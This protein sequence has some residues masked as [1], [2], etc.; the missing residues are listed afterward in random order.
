MGL[1]RNITETVKTVKT[2]NKLRQ[3]WFIKLLLRLFGSK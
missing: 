2:V 1:F 3:N